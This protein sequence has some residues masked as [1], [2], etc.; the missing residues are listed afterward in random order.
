M[1][2]GSLFFTLVTILSLYTSASF[3]Q[4][5]CNG[6]VSAFGCDTHMTVCVKYCANGTQNVPS[7]TG[8]CNRQFNACHANALR[9]CANVCK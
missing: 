8:N 7:C 9:N 3:A 4:G 6:C 2:K 5:A 1:I